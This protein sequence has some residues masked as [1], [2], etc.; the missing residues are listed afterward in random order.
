[1][2]VG[3]RAAGL[4]LRAGAVT[5]CPVV[6]VVVVRRASESSRRDKRESAL[7]RL[8]AIVRAQGAFN[9]GAH[10]GPALAL[11]AVGPGNHEGPE[12]ARELSPDPLDADG[13]DSGK[14]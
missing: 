6:P 8:A 7:L 10:V 12:A 1:V 5:D 3:S 13:K 2:S 14:S 9:L 4:L 11:D